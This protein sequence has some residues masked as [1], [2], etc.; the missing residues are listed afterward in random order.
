MEIDTRRFKGFATR[1]ELVS[2]NSNIGKPFRTNEETEQHLTVDRDGRIWISGYREVRGKNF[3][4]REL[5]EEISSEAANCFLASIGFKFSQD[6]VDWPGENDSYW[7][8]EL[9]NENDEIYKF[10]GVIPTT[11][12][13]LR[14]MSD[15]IRSMIFTDTLFVF[16]GEARFAI[17]AG[18]DEKIFVGTKSI[19]DPSEELHWFFY[20]GNNI[21][22]GDRF[23]A[24]FR[25]GTRCFIVEVTDIIVAK[26]E[27]GPVPKRRLKGVATINDSMRSPL[28]NEVT[29]VFRS[30]NGWN[31]K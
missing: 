17:T 22:I 8:M 12:K 3:K 6:S 19:I 27:E 11:D 4:L 15:W 20:E 31:G 1:M 30:L 9:T 16:D 7:D 25:N 10:R 13:T 21:N 14:D 23:M 5:Q 28:S 18:P 24:P 26:P 2:Y 29:N